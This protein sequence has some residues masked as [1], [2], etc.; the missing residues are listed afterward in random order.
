MLAPLVEQLRDGED[1]VVCAA[2]ASEATL[3]LMI[4]PVVSIYQYASLSVI[5]PG[6]GL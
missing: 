5:K 1:A 4:E 6:A 2:L 3:R